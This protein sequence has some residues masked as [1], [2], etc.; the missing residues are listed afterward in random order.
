[1]GRIYVGG[2]QGSGMEVAVVAPL[3]IHHGET[4]ARHRLDRIATGLLDR[5]HTVTV[6]C[7]RW[8]DLSI[9]RFQQDGISYRAV[10]SSYSPLAFACKLP[11]ILARER[12][13]M[14]HAAHVP[15]SASVSAALARVGTLAPTVLDWYEAVDPAAG[16]LA[17]RLAS[18]TLTPSRMVSADA[19]ERGIPD[20]N[21]TTLPEWV[22]FDT[23]RSVDPIESDLVVSRRLD[24]AANLDAILLALGELRDRDWSLTVIGDGPRRSSYEQRAR[25]LRIADRIEFVGSLPI[26]E[27]VARFRG[28]HA[29]LHTA[30]R[31]PFARELCWALAAGCVGIVQYAERSA[32]HELVEGRDRGFLATE[33]EGIADAIEQGAALDQQT[34]DE[35][36]AEF[37]RPAVLDQLESCYA[38]LGAP[39]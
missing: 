33:P 32:A 31:T 35:S 14:V 39:V 9:P 28:A 27:R 29:I 1:M 5:G 2:L 30:T 17:G 34:I 18:R 26:A 22:R 11:V 7:T 25:D 13:H 23:I 20:G 16:S 21:L 4:A 37:D 38:E 8:W 15:G 3:T 24:E 12:P 19:S 36:Y 6:Y 10:T